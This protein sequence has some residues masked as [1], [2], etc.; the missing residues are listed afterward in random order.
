MLQQ[1]EPADYVIATGKQYSV[2]NLVEVAAACVGRS[3][4][5]EGEGVYEQGFDSD[6]GQC[7]VKIDPRYFRPTEVD[8]LLGDPTKAREELGWVPRIGFE[9]MVREM[10]EDDIRAAE[11]DALCEREGYKTYSYYE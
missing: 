4:R 1:D 3:V 5:W 10:V 6:N 8:T 7:L 9:E 11:R 2:R